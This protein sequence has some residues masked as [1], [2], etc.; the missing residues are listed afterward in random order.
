MQT[1]HAAMYVVS[2]LYYIKEP[3]LSEKE[4]VYMSVK[5]S[6]I[7]ILSVV[8]TMI[9]AA[10]FLAGCEQG[11]KEQ[12]ISDIDDTKTD[13][14]HVEPFPEPVTEPFPEPV[15]EPV[16]EPV[17]ELV[18]E[19][20]TEPE[21]SRINLIMVGDILLHTPVEESAIREDG[22]YNYDAIFANVR[23]EIDKADLAIVNQ[24]VIIGGEE[25]G[26]SGYPA[27]NAPYAVGDALVKAGFDVVCHGTNHALDKGKQGLLNCI[28][29]WEDNYPD[30]E[31]LG[32]HDT[33]EDAEEIV[34]V[35]KDGIKLALLN[36]TY[37][38]NGIPMPEDMSFAVDMLTDAN[39]DKIIEDIQKAEKEADFTIVCPH[40]GTEYSLEIS[41]S[42]KKWT[43][44]F[45]ENGVDLVLGTHPHVI[46][47]VEMIT[48]EET[49]H[50]MLVYYSL[51]NFVNWTSG[52]GEGIANRMVGGM[53]QVTLEKDESGNTYIKEYGIEELVC[54][55]ERGVNGVT[56]YFLDDYTKDLADENEIISQDPEFSLE[57]CLELCQNVWANMYN[58]N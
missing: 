8:L 12:V 25:L 49:G 41:A 55:L 13:A 26:I 54:H 1:Q 58:Y 29:F 23:D 4:K 30:M 32:I 11:K 47:P 57:Y 28:N 43:S 35:E 19:V 38:T 21:L 6:K 9:M 39:K 36:Y 31:V 24:E 50:R 33:K 56:V 7:I 48:D 2:V 42:Q 17:T 10:F 34:Y 3:I 15:T 27:F 44:L 5:K 52:S 20:I 51:G 45:L 14:R 18:P 40:W 53:A 46:E 22:S 37:S 16:P